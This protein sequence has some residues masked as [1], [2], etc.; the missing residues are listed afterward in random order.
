MQHIT[1]RRYVLKS[2]AE[3]KFSHMLVTKVSFLPDNNCLLFVG[4]KEWQP[5]QLPRD[6]AELF[7]RNCK[8]TF[9]NAVA[10]DVLYNMPNIMSDSFFWRNNCSDRKSSRGFCDECKIVTVK[11][12]FE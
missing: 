6:T 3:K 12:D 9:E 5:L 1:F 4:G 11:P 2:L 8:Q 7:E 10:E